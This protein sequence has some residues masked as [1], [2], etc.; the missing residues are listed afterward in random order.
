MNNQKFNINYIFII[1]II[2][3][4]LLTIYLFFKLNKNNEN[5]MSQSI[6]D[7]IKTIY[8]AD[9]QAIR[10]LSNVAASLQAG[11]YTIPGNLNVTG[12]TTNA[13]LNVT[14]LTNTNSLNIG[15]SGLISNVNGNLTIPSIINAQNGIQSKGIHLFG[16]STLN[17]NPLCIKGNDTNHALNYAAN[18]GGCDGPA[19][20]GY[21]G[22]ELGSTNGEYKRALMWDNNQNVKVNGN[23]QVNGN[24]NLN[25]NITI[26]NWTLVGSSDGFRLC[27]GGSNDSNRFWFNK[28]VKQYNFN[29]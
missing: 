9:I 15:N 1:I 18:V 12:T 8:Q 23:L 25:G 7:Q 16:L 10:N 5:F 26:G 29:G 17:Q 11:G 28:N 27:Y 22:G 19:L 20:Y 3:N 21:D 6:S 4:L 24:I 14:G 13:N 2:I